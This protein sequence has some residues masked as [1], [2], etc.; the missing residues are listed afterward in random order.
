MSDNTDIVHRL[1]QQSVGDYSVLLWEAADEIERLRADLDL[2]L[3]AEISRSRIADLARVKAEPRRKVVQLIV[4]PL[5]G[6]HWNE[7]YALCDDGTMWN[8]R[9]P[10]KWSQTLAI[11]QPEQEVTP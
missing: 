7:V 9:E 3:S 8:R 1:R 6:Q 2:A 11:P 10:Q 4:L 5:D